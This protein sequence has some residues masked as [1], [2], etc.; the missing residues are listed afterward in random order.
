MNSSKNSLLYTKH[1]LALK[2][3]AAQ[4]NYTNSMRFPYSA[5]MRYVSTKDWAGACHATASLLYIMLQESGYNAHLV[6]GQ[7]KIRHQYFDHSWVT[8][9][10][11]IFDIAIAFPLNGA[12]YSGPVF[13][14]V[15]LDSGE[16]PL[17]D[18][19]APMVP[20]DGMSEVL[21][22]TSVS[23]YLS[24]NPALD[25]W[26]ILNSLCSRARIPFYKDVLC[27]KYQTKHWEIAQ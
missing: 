14:G 21:K 23:D 13:A 26:E 7:G 25:M 1:D 3:V 5:L 6:L 19:G 12:S 15:D 9:D 16:P 22:T 17:V 8:V 18:Y 2:N 24:N 20:F 10:D 11:R 4:F 27:G